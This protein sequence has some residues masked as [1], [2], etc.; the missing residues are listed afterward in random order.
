MNRGKVH[1]WRTIVLCL[2]G[3]SALMASGRLALAQRGDGQGRIGHVGRVNWPARYFAPYSNDASSETD[4]VALSRASGARFFTLAF[5]E[6]SQDK[7]CQATWN[8]RQP[9]G[10]WMRGSIAALRAHG[11]DV[12]VAFGG[13]ANSELAAVCDT[14]PDLFAQYQATVETYGLSH[15]D[16]DIEGQT[17]KNSQATHLRNQAIAALQRQAARAGRRLNVSYTLPVETTG[18]G[19]SSLHLLRDAIQ[20]GVRVD[21]VNLMIMDYYSKN[22]PG[23]Q[24][25]QNAIAASSSVFSQLQQLYPA[26]SAEQLWGMLGLTPMIGVNDNPAE[27]FTL[28]DAQLIDNFA[29]RRQM[30][31]LSFW[32]IRRDRACADSQ[33]APHGCSGIDQQP[34]D[35]TQI[36]S[37]FGE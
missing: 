8:T 7:T 21:V 29:E 36:F 25:G 22:A 37:A 15:I 2:L 32:S 35:Y 19:Q 9:I 20:T 3:L 33:T 11:G 17:L 23:D 26:K 6:G 14:L 10:S 13:S 12:R 30:A 4:L 27:T 16:F 5:V 28:R 31:L 24:M 18:L 34:Y 1:V